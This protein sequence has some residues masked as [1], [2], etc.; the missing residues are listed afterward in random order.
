MI[1]LTIYLASNKCPY[2][3]NLRHLFA[4]NLSLYGRVVEF[5]L[6]RHIL[7]PTEQLGVLQERH[8]PLHRMLIVV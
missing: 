3:Y 7:L 2:V 5:L 1:A 8:I 4:G 6:L